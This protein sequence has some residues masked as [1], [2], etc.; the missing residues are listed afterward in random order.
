MVVKITISEIRMQLAILRYQRHDNTNK[1]T[2]ESNM[3]YL[4]ESADNTIYL[5]RSLSVTLSKKYPKIHYPR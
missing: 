3:N 5:Y 2:L 4:M 1:G